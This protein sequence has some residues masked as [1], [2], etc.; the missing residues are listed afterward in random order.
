M[1]ADFA[2][3]GA[4]GCTTGVSSTG[5]TVGGTVASDVLVAVRI[6]A[7]VGGTEVTMWAW[8]ANRPAVSTAP[9]VRK[10]FRMSITSPGGAAA[11]LD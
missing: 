5:C 7:E 10:Y 8:S 1:L 2:A 9:T 3:G 11:S 4:A 6:T